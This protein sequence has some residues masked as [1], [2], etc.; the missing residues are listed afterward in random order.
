MDRGKNPEKRKSTENLLAGWLT[1]KKKTTEKSPT[2]VSGVQ[3]GSIT[4]SLQKISISPKVTTPTK[5]SSAS[6]SN[7]ENIKKKLNF[8][9]TEQISNAGADAQNPSET[10]SFIKEHTRKTCVAEMRRAGLDE[11][12]KW[13]TKAILESN[14][15]GYTYLWFKKSDWET[16]KNLPTIDAKMMI[17]TVL[18]VGV[19][20]N[21]GRFEDHLSPFSIIS[22]FDRHLKIALSISLQFILGK[23]PTRICCS[24]V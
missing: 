24:R 10:W 8:T 16:I 23:N 15:P 12:E 1:K 17:D 18:Y 22:P 4:S 7:A 13:K 5:Q 3:V 6:S 21:V 11:S 19:D 9:S 14:A 2:K 20:V